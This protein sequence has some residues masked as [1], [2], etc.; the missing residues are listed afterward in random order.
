MASSLNTQQLSQN[1]IPNRTQFRNALDT[2]KREIFLNI[3]CHHLVTIQSFNPVKQTAT[4]TV[5]YTK[6]FTITD[7]ITKQVSSKN[8]SYPI[9]LDCPVV[10]LGGGT[11]ALTF[12][13]APGDEGLALF[14]DRDIDNWYSGNSSTN[15]NSTRLHSFGDGIILV[16]VRSLPHV[17]LDYDTDAVCLRFG[18]NKI[19][20][21]ATKFTAALVS[22]TSIEIDATGKLKITNLTGE[23]VSMLVQLFNDIQ[24]GLVTTLLGPEPLVMPTFAADLALLETFKA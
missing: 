18:E 16:G 2:L 21:N 10:C 5:N 7:P 22:G 4:A 8:V 24:T 3:N 15:P 9:L 1:A 19:K 17:I 6:S 14:N 23:F 11:G 13:I 20:I 12:P